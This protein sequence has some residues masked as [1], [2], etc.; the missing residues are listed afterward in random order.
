MRG[1]PH[2]P[3]LGDT[4]TGV[5]ACVARDGE[6]GVKGLGVGEW[7]S[8][9]K[10][11]QE[12]YQLGPRKILGLLWRRLLPRHGCYWKQVFVHKPTEHESKMYWFN[13]VFVPALKRRI[14]MVSNL[15]DIL[16]G[17]VK[18]FLGFTADGTGRRGVIFAN[19]SCISGPVNFIGDV[20]PSDHIRPRIK[21][22]R[23]KTTL[24]QLQ[25]FVFDGLPKGRVL[26]RQTQQIRF[27]FLVAAPPAATC[28]SFRDRGPQ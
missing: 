13:R 18:P 21:I 3:E 20:L 26:P 1:G 6:A 2:P 25:H 19:K 12:L 9:G 4:G 10:A 28:I 16:Y 8:S 17:A 24:F 11:A 22:R 27:A 15:P 14:S 5:V 23:C 7:E